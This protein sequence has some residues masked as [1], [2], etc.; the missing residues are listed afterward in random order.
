MASAPVT[1]W[2]VKSM[3][4]AI[5]SLTELVR[6]KTQEYNA[7]LNVQ[8]VFDPIELPIE[9]SYYL[10]PD[11]TVIDQNTVESRG[12]F[13]ARQH[14]GEWNAT[15]F[16]SESFD[17]YSGEFMLAELLDKSPDITWW[18]RLYR[19]EQAYIY[20]TITDRYFPDFAALDTSGR[21]WIIEGKS[22]KGKSDAEVQAKKAAAES[23]I[24]RMNSHPEFAGKLYGYLIG[25][26]STIASSESWAELVEKAKPAITRQYG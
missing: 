21:L 6:Q 12:Q 13:V 15:M 8:V 11:S 25:Y 18:K 22:E 23:I 17:S 1:E 14:Y 5:A 10:P 26:E 4:S 2:T 7:R 16:S 20:Y 24:R 9:N 19:H 3:A